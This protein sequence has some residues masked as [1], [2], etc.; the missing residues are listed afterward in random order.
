MNF[1]TFIYTKET[2]YK[3]K[4]TFSIIII[5]IIII[6]HKTYYYFINITYKILYVY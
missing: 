6:T 5:I 3:I 4:K 1:K 2:F